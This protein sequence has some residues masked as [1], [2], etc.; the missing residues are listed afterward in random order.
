MC[1]EPT[2]LSKSGWHVNLNQHHQKAV[3]HKDVP[4]RSD[5]KPA[6]YTSDEVASAPSSGEVMCSEDID[7]CGWLVGW[8][9]TNGKAT[10]F[11]ISLFLV[12]VVVVVVVIVV[13]VCV[14]DCLH[15]EWTSTAA[16]RSLDRNRR[17]RRTRFV[18]QPKARCVVISRMPP[19]CSRCVLHNNNNNNNLNNNNNNNNKGCHLTRQSRDLMH[20]GSITMACIVW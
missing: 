19:I 13:V 3:G 8:L 17:S 4:E 5:P 20:H 2:P 6:I 14:V 1:I 12:V 11:S 16:S 7:G 9:D 10:G 15:P 18:S